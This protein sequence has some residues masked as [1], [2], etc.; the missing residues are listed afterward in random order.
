MVTGESEKAQI[1]IDGADDLYREIRIDNKLVDG[2]G[3]EVKLKS[4][5]EVDVTIEAARG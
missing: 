3:A 4:G 5:A 1:V 2:D